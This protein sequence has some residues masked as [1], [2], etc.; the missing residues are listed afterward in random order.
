[1]IVCGSTKVDANIAR[2]AVECVVI[3]R[4]RTIEPVIE[5]L[6]NDYRV[7]AMEQTESSTRIF[8]YQ[9]PR[10]TALLLGHERN[11]VSGGQ[12]ELAHDVIEI[13]VYGK[14]FSYNVVTAATMAVY[15]YCR[16]FPNG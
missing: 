12:L 1:M 8:D 6:R 15:E 2:D 11:G 7:V 9:F 13:P 3:E 4:H 5:R 10:R 14:P 16:Q